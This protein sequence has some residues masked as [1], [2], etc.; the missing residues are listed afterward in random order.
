MPQSLGA[1]A[2][3][4]AV[5]GVGR[6]GRRRSI[7]VLG[8]SALA[9]VA[10]AIF[11]AAGGWWTPWASRYIQGVDVSHHQGAIDWPTLGG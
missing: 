8:F 7:L 2:P 1:P 3:S 6:R 9:L 5:T 4:P 11:A 10:L